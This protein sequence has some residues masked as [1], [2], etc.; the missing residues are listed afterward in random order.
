MVNLV[1][2]RSWKE[3]IDPRGLDAQSRTS[4]LLDGIHF[5][6]IILPF[7]GLKLAPGSIV[8]GVL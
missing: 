3:E 4:R 2:K 5:P 1:L 6:I 8:T 7:S